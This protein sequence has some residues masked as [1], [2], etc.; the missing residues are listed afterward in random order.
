MSAERNRRQ[1]H[2]VYL[3]PD[4]VFGARLSTVDFPDRELPVKILNLS[5]GGLFFICNKSR[6]PSFREGEKIFLDSIEGPCPV[7]FP[8]KIILEIRWIN[9]NPALDNAGYGCEFIDLPL[10][11][12]QMIR[13][14][15]RHYQ[16]VAT[17]K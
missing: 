8:R 5:E 4:Q 7:S 13:E 9:E 6:G 3:D 11:K 17:P 16:E 12:K 10:H 1:H 14:I 15:V 2:R